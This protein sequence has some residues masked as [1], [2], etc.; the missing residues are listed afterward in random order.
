M[1]KT[2]NYRKKGVGEFSDLSK[3]FRVNVN[4]DFIQKYEENPKRFYKFTGIFSNMY[5]ASHKNGNIITPFGIKN[6]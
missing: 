3:T 6:K 5:D 2:L 4:K 1:N